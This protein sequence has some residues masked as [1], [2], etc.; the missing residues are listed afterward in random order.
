MTLVEVIVSIAL[1]G[2]ITT[3]AFLVFSTGILLAFRS[4]DNTEVTGEGSGI[5]ENALGGA[6]ITPGPDAELQVLGVTIG[7]GQY[8]EDDTAY[9]TVRFSGVVT[10]TIP[11]SFVTVYS[12]SD[13]NTTTMAAF[14]P[15]PD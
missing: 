14:I 5:L 12:E 8:T 3:M 2:I 11:G 4:G 1:L 7:E 15:N 13:E 10:E 9:A 6:T